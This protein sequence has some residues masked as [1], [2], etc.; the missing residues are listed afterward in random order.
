MKWTMYNSPDCDAS[1]TYTWLDGH[2]SAHSYA[3]S[4]EFRILR[5]TFYACYL[6]GFMEVV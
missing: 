5:R 6:L 2:D 1:A 3:H 4:N